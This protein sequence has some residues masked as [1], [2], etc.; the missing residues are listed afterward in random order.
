ARLFAR[1]RVPE[2]EA[3]TLPLRAPPAWI[4]LHG[5]R[6]TLSSTQIRAEIRGGARRPNGVLQSASEPSTF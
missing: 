6:S 3:R 2:A 1:N 5:P 4:F